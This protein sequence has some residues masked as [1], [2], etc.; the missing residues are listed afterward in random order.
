MQGAAASGTPEPHP[1]QAPA[2]GGGVKDVIPSI[3][4]RYVVREETARRI[5]ECLRS[6]GGRSCQFD[7]PEFGGAGQWMP[8]MV[9]IRDHAD[10]DLKAKV[11]GL[12]SELSAIVQGSNTSAPGTLDCAGKPP[13][14][15]GTTD[16]GVGESW[17]PA[18]FGRP[19]ASGEQCGVRYAHF[20]ALRR[21]LV[22]RGA[23]IDA[24]DTGEHVISGVAQA[25][26]QGSSVTFSSNRGPVG[27]EQL[28]CV[29]LA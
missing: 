12:C 22:Q 17:W 3:A 29:P 2:A 13:A 10:R 16:M 28:K 11:D 21:L 24:Y 26:G 25:Q 18:S 8:G 6:T 15:V 1:S 20:P 9:M 23:H 27:L 5:F 19:A 7:I 4:E 14:A